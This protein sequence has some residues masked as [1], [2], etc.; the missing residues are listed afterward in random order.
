MYIVCC[1][2]SEAILSFL[3]NFP[4][5]LILLYNCEHISRMKICAGLLYPAHKNEYYIYI[6][7]INCV[8][9]YIYINAIS[10]TNN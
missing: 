8:P 1:C 9:I 4:L 2:L 3:N 6:Y 7:I 5:V 10:I